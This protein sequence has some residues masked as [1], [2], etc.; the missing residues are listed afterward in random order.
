MSSWIAILSTLH[1]EKSAAPADSIR[2]IPP[3]PIAAARAGYIPYKVRRLPSP[4]VQIPAPRSI[5]STCGPVPEIAPAS[6][7]A[8]R[9]LPASRVSAAAI[10]APA[11][12]AAYGT[13]RIL[14]CARKLPARAR[15]PVAA[16]C[17]AGASFRPHASSSLPPFR[18]RSSSRRQR[19]V[20]FQRSPQ[21][22]PGA[23]QQHIPAMIGRHLV[24]PRGE[25]PRRVV[26]HQLV[27]QFHEDF[28]RGV[29]GIFPR[30]Q[31]TTAKPENRGR[32][33]P[34]KL[35]PSLGVTR[36]GTGN[37]LRRFLY[38]RRAHPAW[39]QRFHRL[40]RAETRKYYT[41][42]IPPRHRSCL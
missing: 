28:H 1:P 11:L 13:C 26:L 6:R 18:S 32:A 30:R 38:S 3:A 41:L 17:T 39:S 33:I 22:V 27:L 23:Q 9:P 35:A 15:A 34:V 25:R 36:P 24:K 14:G 31:G 5:A 7:V 42:Q 29:F 8:V 16:R 10:R 20:A 2:R 40:V 37:R 19:R 12:A 21:L 4:P